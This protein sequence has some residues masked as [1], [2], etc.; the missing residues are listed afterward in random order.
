MMIR[1]MIKD[2]ESTIKL[3]DKNKTHKLVGERHAGKR[4]HGIGTG[5]DIG[6]KSVRTAN[7]KYQTTRTRSHTLLNKS[8]KTNRRKLIATLIEKN[9]KIGLFK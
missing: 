4:N 1:F 7:D 5:I 8:R 6:R 9:D 2:G 3:L